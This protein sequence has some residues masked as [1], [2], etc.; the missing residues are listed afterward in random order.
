M[1]HEIGKGYQHIGADVRST[2]YAKEDESDHTQ[3]TK[4]FPQYPSQVWPYARHS[5]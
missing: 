3:T 2:Q 1:Q 5:H 4:R